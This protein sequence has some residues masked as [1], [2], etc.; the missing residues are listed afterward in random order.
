[1]N[2]DKDAQVVLPINKEDDIKIKL[3]S[4]EQNDNGAIWTLSI[5]ETEEVDDDEEV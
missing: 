4:F 5:E 3:V 2:K 1:M